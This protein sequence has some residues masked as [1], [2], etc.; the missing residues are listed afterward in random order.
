M[1]KIVKVLFLVSLV[2]VASATSQEVAGGDVV[3]VGRHP[4][5]VLQESTFGLRAGGKQNLWKL[6]D[7]NPNFV[8]YDDGLVIFKKQNDPH[9]LFSVLLGPA[10]K[11]AMLRKLNPTA[12]LTLDNS[13]S[14]NNQLDQPV[15]FIKYWQEGGMKKVRVIGDIR[16]STSDRQKVPAAFLE[17]FDQMISF[18]NSNAVV[19]QP[20]LM[21]I[22]LYA[23][24]KSSGEPVPWP[25]E[26]PDLNH[27]DTRKRTDPAMR[28][29]YTLYLD[30]M[31]RDRLEKMLAGL[32]P[33][34][35][36]LINGKHWYLA[37][38]RFIL[39]NEKMWDTEKTTGPW[40]TIRRSAK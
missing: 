29:A 4:I 2:P 23:H 9:Q 39:P 35:A 12:F 20:G 7:L 28:Y 13:Y 22:Q 1:H 16:N 14:T 10:E 15:Y 26:W 11:K 18:G 25:D 21:E 30:G 5:F 6:G 17:P 31:H 36:V 40:D 3:A 38:S 32:K 24:R 34:Q 37:P 27:K 8:L 19:W 33:R